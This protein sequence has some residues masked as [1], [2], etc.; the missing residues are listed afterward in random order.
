MKGYKYTTE[1]E[2]QAE[3]D[4]IDV[5]IG[6][7]KGPK[8]TQRWTDYKFAEFNNPQFYYIVEH[9]S[10]NSLLG[11]SEDLNVIEEVQQ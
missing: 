9:D 6:L 1:Q 8:D 11:D 2:A 7:P 10:F 4:R 5:F 3:L